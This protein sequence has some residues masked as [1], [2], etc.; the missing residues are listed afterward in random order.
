MTDN[1]KQQRIKNVCNLEIGGQK[2]IPILLPEIRRVVPS[3]S[4]TFHWL[5]QSWQFSNLYDESTQAPALLDTF[6]NQY[7]DSRDRLA[8]CSLSEWLRTSTTSCITAVTEQMAFRKFYQSDFYHEIL[9]P[10]NY[11]HSLYLGIKRGSAPLGI[12]VLHR[13]RGDRV[14]SQRDENNLR[15]LGPLIAPALRQKE[16]YA[17]VLPRKRGTGLCLLDRQGEVRQINPQARKLL[18]LA[19]YPV[20]RKGRRFSPA[21]ESLLPRRVKSLARQLYQKCSKGDLPEGKRPGLEINN[22]W[23]H[24]LFEFDW[25]QAPESEDGPEGAVAVSI[26]QQEPILYRALSE[27][28]QL[29]FTARQ[30]EVV[31]WLLKGLSRTEI[32]KKIHVSHYTVN[33]HVKKIYQKLEICNRTGLFARLV[34]SAADSIKTGLPSS[35]GV[36]SS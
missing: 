9:K 20:I 18:M 15:E 4:S 10:M 13:G 29:G 34:S 17:G 14:F 36:L 6:I 21:T 24:F 27:C 33:D 8:R 5:D 26:S 1:K 23:G 11:H 31:F 22:P 25:L 35:P 2:L 30:S 28:D 7:L 12:L 19:K 3:R 32:S 16:A